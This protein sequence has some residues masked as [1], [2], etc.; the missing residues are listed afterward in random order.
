MSEKLISNI[1]IRGERHKLIDIPGKEHNL[2][3]MNNCPTTLWIKKEKNLFED[4]VEYIPWIDIGTNRQSWGISIQQGN[5]M[6]YKYNSYDIIGFTNVVISLNNTNV[7]E[8]YSNN[9]EYAFNKAQDKIYKLKEI[10]LVL[11]DLKSDIGR[12]IY[13]KS[14]PCKIANRFYDG[15]LILNPDCNDNELENWWNNFTEPWYNENDYERIEEY[16]NFGEIKVDILSEKIFWWR[17]D[18]ETK[19]NKLKKHIKKGT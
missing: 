9:L 19:L 10:P 18:R 1:I 15:S 3:K 14:L 16:K 12:K 4:E 6:N 11:D 7:Y 8:F 13:Y 2:G 17:N 5:T